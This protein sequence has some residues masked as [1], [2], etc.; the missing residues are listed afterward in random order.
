MPSTSASITFNISILLAQGFCIHP[1]SL[2]AFLPILW[3]PF[4]I[5]SHP[6]KHFW[7]PFHLLNICFFWLYYKPLFPACL[8]A[9]QAIC[10][11]LEITGSAKV[12]FHGLGTPMPTVIGRGDIKISTTTV[13]F[14]NYLIPQT[15]VLEYL[16]P[17]SCH[18]H[19]TSSCIGFPWCIPSLTLN[20]VSCFYSSST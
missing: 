1:K 6:W 12:S 13:P 20:L 9:L 7:S 8:V 14:Q 16:G 15:S 5:L 4:E 17:G 10:K 18:L 19:Q 2:P 3:G 11:L